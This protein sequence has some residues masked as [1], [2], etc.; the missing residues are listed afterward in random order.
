[1][2]RLQNLSYLGYAFDLQ[3]VLPDRRD[4]ALLCRPVTRVQTINL[5]K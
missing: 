4:P 2:C 1:M 5:Y 3:T